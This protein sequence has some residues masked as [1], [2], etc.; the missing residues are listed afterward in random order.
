MAQW[1]KCLRCKPEDLSSDPQQ[2]CKKPGHGRCPCHS[3]AWEERQEHGSQRFAGQP[4]SQLM[5]SRL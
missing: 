4:A 5:S 3:S 1:V 2:S